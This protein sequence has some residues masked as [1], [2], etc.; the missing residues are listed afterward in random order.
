MIMKDVKQRRLKTILE[1]LEKAQE[2]I[3]G[4]QLSE[5]L[6]VSRQVIVQDIAYLRSLGYNII[7]TPRGYVLS[8][9]RSKISKLIAVKHSPESI[10][11]ELLCIVRN[12]GRVVDVIVEHPVY[13]EIRGIID[14]SSEEEVLKF[15]SLMEMTKTEPLLT[16][17]GGV[18]LHTIEAPDEETMEKILKELKKRGFLVGEE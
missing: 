2:P 5:K 10:K 18:H 3:S 16:L 8:G 6:K 17:S 15:V 14:V 9:G 13:G 1:V 4:S 7:S 11:E 12:G